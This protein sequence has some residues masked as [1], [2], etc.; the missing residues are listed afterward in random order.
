MVKGILMALGTLF[1][2]I[3][4]WGFIGGQQAQETGITC[5]MGLG[6][7]FCWTWH[8]NIVG[9]AQE[10]LDNAGNTVKNFLN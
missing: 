5:D 6:K 4:I 3:L 2:V 1:L 7:L 10:F 9:Q 8:T